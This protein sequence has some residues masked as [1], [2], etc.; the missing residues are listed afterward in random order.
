MRRISAKSGEEDGNHPRGA[1]GQFDSRDLLAALDRCGIGAAVTGAD[2]KFKW[3]SRTFCRMTGYRAG[4]LRS[5]TWASVAHAASPALE[6]ES[7]RHMFAGKPTEFSIGRNK[8]QTLW[9]CGAARRMAREANQKPGFILVLTD[10]TDR[11]Q[12]EQT[13]RRRIA[14]ELHDTTGQSLAALVATL[15][16][17]RDSRADTAPSEIVDDSIELAKQAAREIR[18]LSFLLY[19][20]EL[21]SLDLATALR[22]Y[23]DGF[24]TRS[25]IDVLL[26]MPKKLPPVAREGADAL[27]HVVL[28]S[29]NNAWR[30]SGSHKVT[31]SLTAPRNQILLGI[32]DFGRGNRPHPDRP[33]VAGLSGLGI[34]AMRDRMRLLGGDL[35]V[36]FG[37][38]GTVVKARLPL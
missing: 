24:S 4:D 1:H 10:I 15:G 17:L 16:Q 38:R 13:E 32:R 22:Q 6:R 25:G 8:G 21:S 33:G 9:V 3:A 30:H 14:R 35:R 5:L 20:P 2:G 36:E 19:P 37:S 18:T 34:P 31:I 7:T 26:K 23:V 27:F 12:V 11:K 29:L 28:E